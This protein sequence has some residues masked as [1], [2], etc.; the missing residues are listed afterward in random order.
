MTMKTSPLLKTK[1]HA[2]R[3]QAGLVD[4]SRIL[5]ALD[6]I[7]ARRLT[8]ISASAGFGKTTAIGAWLERSKY[9][10]AWVSLD[11]GDNSLARFLQYV[12]ASLQ[13]IDPRI[14]EGVRRVIET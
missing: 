12:V 11:I 10:A 7:P 14:G 6:E 1:I 13:N 8:L 5:D 2:V 9:P 3:P 4:R